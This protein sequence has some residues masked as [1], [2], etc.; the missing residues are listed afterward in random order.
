MSA[1]DLLAAAAESM[2]AV[3]EVAAA[4]GAAAELAAD[5]IKAGGT[6]F[7]CGNGGSAADA[8]HLAAELLGRFLK[9][10]PAYASVA[11][12]TNV[13]AVTAIGNDYGFDLVFAR[14]L[15]G[16]G[17]R[18]DVLV[19]LSTSGRSAN[20]IKAFEAARELGISTV[21]MT[22]AA[23]SPLSKM[24]DIAI[25]VPSPSTPRIQ[26]MHIVVGHVMCEL[27]ESTL[28]A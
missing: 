5:A 14:Q 21:A 15:M 23:E 7:F 18:G 11:L 24:A 2:A 10:R 13:S 27:I 28:T 3:T 16:L 4:A 20:V 8:Q 6:V 17:R 9:E 19:G 12:P 25:R 26:E 1:R 22:G